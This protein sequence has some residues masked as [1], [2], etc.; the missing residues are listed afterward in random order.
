MESVAMACGVQ[1][2][3]RHHKTVLQCVECNH[4]MTNKRNVLIHKCEKHMDKTTLDCLCRKECG[5]TLGNVHN[6]NQHEKVCTGT[7]QIT[8]GECNTPF[9][10]LGALQK[11]MPSHQKREKPNMPQCVN[12]YS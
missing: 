9:D 7:S 2:V 4:C 6:Q 11:H 5:K 12:V 8:C 1:R 10:T 3:H